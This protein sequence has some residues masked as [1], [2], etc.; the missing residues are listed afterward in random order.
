M[1]GHALK[2][3]NCIRINK[4]EYEKI[5][6]HILSTIESLKLIKLSVL[7]EA[8]EKEDF[9]DLDILYLS[10]QH[11]NMCDLIKS[12]FNPKEVVTN[13]DVISFS[14]QI[15]ESEY[16]QIDMIKT[17]NIEMSQFY[18]GY[19]DCGNIIGRFTKRADLTFGNEG[20]WTSYESKKIILST[21][22]QE[23][24]EYLGLNYNL[25][26]A[27]FN[28][29]TELFNW[30]T[31]SRYFDLN[32]FRFDTLNAVYRHRYDTRPMFKEFVD[33]LTTLSLQTHEI[34]Q[35]SEDK[36]E[37][38][39]YFNKKDEKDKIDEEIRIIRLHQK[40]FSG[41]I[42]LKYV[43]CK[44]INNYKKNFQCYIENKLKEDFNDWL[45]KNNTEFIE[46]SIKEFISLE[47]N[48]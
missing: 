6:N 3:V 41:K 27:G 47:P 16:F 23:I 25:W 29:R 14:Y 38:I 24:C 18:G 17:S 7:I 1:G 35:I 37:H 28:T 44:E 42:F 34:S 10:N 20:L 8:P 33:Y 36:S 19:G 2:H 43:S 5:K 31:E 4:V 45:S 48:H 39:N 30:I 32:L 15:S 26:S 46:N 21:I 11:I 40:K 22:P 9:G 13:G 12:T